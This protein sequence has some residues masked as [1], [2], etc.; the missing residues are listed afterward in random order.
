MTDDMMLTISLFVMFTFF[1]ASFI[2]YNIY[3]GVH[4]SLANSDIG[5]VYNFRYFQPVTGDY[6]RLLAQVVKVRKLNDHEIKK[7]NCISDYRMGDKEFQRTHTLVTCRMGNGE[8]RQFYAE[9]SDMCRR[10]VL[11]GMLFKMGVAHLF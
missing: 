9:R 1:I 2:F 5:D 7:L 4:G 6:Q 10:P 8:Y 3:W 11:A